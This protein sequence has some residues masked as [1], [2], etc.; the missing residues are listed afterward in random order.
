[1]NGRHDRNGRMESGCLRKPLDTKFSYFDEASQ[2]PNPVRLLLKS[3]AR[4]N[5]LIV[6]GDPKQMPSLTSFFE[7][8]TKIRQGRSDLESILDTV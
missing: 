4:G 2:M 5:S 7:Y 1:M 3:I 8:W 6:V